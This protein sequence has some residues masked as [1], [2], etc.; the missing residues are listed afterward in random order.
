VD[1]AAAGK[2]PAE[3]PKFE[4]GTVAAL[5]VGL[6]AISTMVGGAL[7]GFVGL[8]WWMPLGIIGMVFLISGPSMLIAWLKLRQRTLGPILEGTGWAINGRVKIN[9]PL[10]TYLTDAKE[11]PPGAKRLLGDPFSDEKEKQRRKNLTILTV[12]VIVILVVLWFSRGWLQAKW[13]AYRNPPAATETTT[14]TITT[15]SATTTTRPL[16]HRLLCRRR[17]RQPLNPP[18]PSKHPSH[19]HPGPRLHAA[20]RHQ[21]GGD[22]FFVVGQGTAAAGVLPR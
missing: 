18:N 20:R 6:G 13:D 14:T 2:P 1:T 12:V 8:G 9:I 11:L 16:R 19:E 5:G 3:K 10:G 15:P 17:P 4:V 7:A 22:A 21:P